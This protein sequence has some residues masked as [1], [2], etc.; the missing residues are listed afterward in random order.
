MVLEP[1][2]GP[3]YQFGMDETI[4]IK[5]FGAPQERHAVGPYLVLI[6]GHD[7]R[8]HLARESRP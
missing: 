1:L 7:L 6:W 2:P 5:S 8:P 4:C 3:N